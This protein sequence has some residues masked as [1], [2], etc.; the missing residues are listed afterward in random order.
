MKRLF[1]SL[2]VRDGVVIVGLSLFAAGR[3]LDS[4]ASMM[5]EVGAIMMAIGLFKYIAD[6]IARMTARKG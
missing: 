6:G 3:Y 2:S 4:P 1:K 5:I